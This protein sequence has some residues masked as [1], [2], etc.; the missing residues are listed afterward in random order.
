[1]YIYVGDIRTIPDYLNSQL[2]KAFEKLRRIENEMHYRYEGCQ[3]SWLSQT[4]LI[5]KYQSAF[6]RL[7]DKAEKSME[8]FHNQGLLHFDIKGVL[9]KYAYVSTSCMYTVVYR[10]VA[11]FHT[12]VRPR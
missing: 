4:S 5:H 10:T 12:W 9:Y 2:A 7:I 6:I 8:M 3:S 1:M 11:S